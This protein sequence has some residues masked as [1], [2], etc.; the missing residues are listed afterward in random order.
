MIN[1]ACMTC[2]APEL[3]GLRRPLRSK[4]S[5]G[6][7]EFNTT[8]KAHNQKCYKSTETT[9]ETIFSGF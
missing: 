8:N 6:T 1:A 2:L 9:N 3:M 5:I 4:R 7:A